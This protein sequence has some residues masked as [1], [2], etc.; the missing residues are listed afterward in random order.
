MNVS[1]VVFDLFGSIVRGYTTI[2]YDCMLSAIAHALGVPPADF[3]MAWTATF[4]QRVRGEY[5]SVAGALKS[6]AQ[7]LGV[8]PSDEAIGAGI[9]ARISAVRRA[10]R[11]FPGALSVLEYL[12]NG[13]VRLGLVSNCS[14]PVP[15]LWRRHAAAPLLDVAVFSSEVGISKPDPRIF[16]L[17]SERLGLEPTACVYVG[18]GGSDEL[19]GAAEVG[20]HPIRV[21]TDQFRIDPETAEWPAIKTL[22]ELPNLI[23]L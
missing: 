7:R 1:G 23:G 13:Q 18:D 11:P 16:I 19:T 3:K 22:S 8:E 10:L 2:E 17:V 20:M 14:S 15:E 4:S 5:G 21:E 6:L 12:R 9:R